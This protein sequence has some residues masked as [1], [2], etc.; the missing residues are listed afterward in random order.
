MHVVLNVEITIAKVN[1]LLVQY[2]I[3]RNVD[4]TIYVTQRVSSKS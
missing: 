4:L 3:A 1:I 2:E